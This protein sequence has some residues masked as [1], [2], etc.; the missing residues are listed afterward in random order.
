VNNGK[1][2]SAYFNKTFYIISPGVLEGNFAQQH[3]PEIPV[4]EHFS[5]IKN[6]FRGQKYLKM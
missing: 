5:P 6:V 4:K 2:K 1:S 3:S